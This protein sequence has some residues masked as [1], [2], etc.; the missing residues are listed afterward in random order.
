MSIHFKCPWCSTVIR[1]PARFA[2]R[3]GKCPKCAEAVTIPKEPTEE[4]HDEQTAKEVD[5]LH[6]LAVEEEQQRPQR[7]ESAGEEW[8]TV[9][10]EPPE[11]PAATEK[12]D[13]EPWYYKFAVSVANVCILL[14]LLAISVF[15]VLLAVAVTKTLQGEEVWFWTLITCLCGIGASILAIFP[16]A[17]ILVLVDMARNI[18]EIR[19]QR[20]G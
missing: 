19:S 5:E 18:R 13:A 10:P 11:K 7:L 1:V 4:G 12:D 15:V 14:D 8:R 9:F 17:M 3:S 2:G 16:M 6:R 20:T